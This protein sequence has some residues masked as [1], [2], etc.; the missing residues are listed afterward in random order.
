MENKYR[1]REQFGFFIIEKK[2]TSKFNIYGGWFGTKI[3]S[4]K[5]TSDWVSVFDIRD[6][7]PET[8]NC[9]ELRFKTLQEAKDYIPKLE[10]IYHDIE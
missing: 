3:I 8:R 9:D 1:I 4:T 2:S 5:T 7:N 10:P 6:T